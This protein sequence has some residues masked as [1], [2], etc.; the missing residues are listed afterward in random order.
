MK[1]KYAVIECYSCSLLG[2]YRTLDEAVEAMNEAQLDGG[3]YRI[4]KKLESYDN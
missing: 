3:C 2:T 4:F 1:D